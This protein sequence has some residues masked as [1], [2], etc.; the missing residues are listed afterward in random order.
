VG[1][2]GKEEK[3][4]GRDGKL[5]LYGETPNAFPVAVKRGNL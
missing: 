4:P 3:S 5:G 1:Q 2:L